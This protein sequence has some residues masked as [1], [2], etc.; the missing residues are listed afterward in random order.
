MGNIIDNNGPFSRSNAY[1]SQAPV[2]AQVTG[3]QNSESATAKPAAK[4]GDSHVS[5]SNSV[6]LLQQVQ[7]NIDAEPVVDANQVAT[8]KAAIDTGTYQI[9]H[10]KIASR[11]LSIDRELP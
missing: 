3:A 6:A 5:F 11:L 8:A 4:H 2:R 10:A 9:D 7:S 1:A